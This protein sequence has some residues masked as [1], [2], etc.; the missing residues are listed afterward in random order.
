MSPR[1]CRAPPSRAPSSSRRPC[2]ARPPG[3]LSQ[4]TSARTTLKGVSEPVTLYRIVR[5]SG[6]GRRGGARVAHAPRRAR[7][8]ARSSQPA[9]GARARRRGPAR[10]H[11][12]RARHRQVTADRGVSRPARRDAAHLGRMVV[13]ATAA[14]YAAAP[15]RRMG[16]PAVR[17]PICPREQRLADLENTL[18]LI[19]LD[20]AEYAPLVAPLVDVALPEDRARE[21]RAG[22]IAA[23]A[24]GGDDGLGSGGRAD[25]AGRARLRGP[26]LGRPDLARS[27][28]GAGRARRPGAAAHRRDDAAGVPPALERALRTIASSR[29]RPSIAR[30]SR[31]WSANLALASRAVAR[32]SSRA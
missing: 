24:T 16:P 31:A 29:S 11:R 19:G 30:R 7:G 32:M 12:R 22:G 2:N 15:D 6:G 3:C 4:R 23:P 21:I 8:R 1:A 20:A 27:D 26:A 28:A 10:A 17:T 25:A 14:E 5:A 18:G 9:L 13:V